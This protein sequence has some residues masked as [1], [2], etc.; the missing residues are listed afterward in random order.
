VAFFH[1]DQSGLST[2]TKS[3][4]NSRHFLTACGF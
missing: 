3:N 1:F 2:H 4:E